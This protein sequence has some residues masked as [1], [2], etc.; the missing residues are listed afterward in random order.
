MVARESTTMLPVAAKVP[1]AGLYNSAAFVAGKS[2]VSRRRPE[3]V[4]S[5][6]S[7]AV[8]VIHVAS[9]QSAPVSANVPLDGSNNSRS[10]EGCHRSLRRPEPS[11]LEAAQQVVAARL[12]HR[13]G[14][15]E[16]SGGRIVDLRRVGDGWRCTVLAP[17]ASRPRPARDRPATASPCARCD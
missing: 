5:D 12:L 2:R 9:T 11:R 1:V 8:A 6:S 15:G 13:P 14:E 7:V 3:P 16:L 10:I 17:P 4:R